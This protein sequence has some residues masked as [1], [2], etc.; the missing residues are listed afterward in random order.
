LINGIYWEP[1]YP[2]ILSKQDIRQLRGGNLVSIAD[3]SCDING[4]IELTSRATSI[5]EPFI[6]LGT[7]F[8]EIMAIDNLP[9]QF[10]RESSEHFASQ[11]NSIIGSLAEGRDSNIIQ[12]AT[13]VEKGQ[14]TQPYQGLCSVMT[15]AKTKQVLLL[16]S[17]FV[18]GPVVKYLSECGHEVIIA[19]NSTSE[20]S[21]LAQKYKGSIAIS[22]DIAKDQDRLLKLCRNADIVVSLLPA[23]MHVPIAEV[24][25]AAGRHLVTASYISEG[26]AKLHDE[27]AEKGLLFLNELGL[28]PGLDHL[29]AKQI[30]DRVHSAGE[31]IIGFESW[32]GGLPAPECADNP[33]GYKFSW[34]PRG[35]LLAALNPAQ[36]LENGTKK[37]IDGSN[38]LNSVVSSPV[39]SRLAL[40]GLYNRDSLKYIHA[41]GLDK[42][43][44]RTMTRGTLR[45]Q[46]FAH[47][48]SSLAGLG[49]L[50]TEPL[51][52]PLKAV[53][54]WEGVF[55]KLKLDKNISLDRQ[56]RSTMQWLGLNSV[57]EGFDGNSTSLLDAFC[58]LLQ[59]KLRYEPTERDMIFM[60]HKFTLRNPKSGQQR[61]LRSTLLE[62]GHEDG[63]SAMARTVGYPV[64]V[65]TQLLLEGKIGLRGVLAPLDKC[66]YEPMLERL[67]AI[68]KISFKEQEDCVNSEI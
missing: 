40:E 52:P 2:R 11:L 21:A 54:S 45:Y 43:C 46:G 8:P 15:A 67:N 60:Q 39:Q 59:K 17:G 34:S 20:A 61:I 5:D 35:V 3:I 23:A 64:A 37:T 4:S 63:F 58:V 57:E 36:F 33:L 9:A 28:D 44:L 22:L 62:F 31:E 47:I 51:S 55:E 10:P 30:I 19:S 56:V 16:G 41:Y 6:Q 68:A 53:T 26:M 66:I 65:A 50:S 32:C 24:C 29:S 48:L 27:A 25:L 13:I 7:E 1:R 12:R 18:A 14:L 49:Y 38:L 42:R